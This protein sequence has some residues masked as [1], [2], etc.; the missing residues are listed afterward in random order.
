MKKNSK[1]SILE[2]ISASKDVV[3]ILAAICV[4][5]WAII[6]V[7]TLNEERI[8]DLKVIEL[9]QKIEK[10]S[11]LNSTM[12]LKAH[13][14][15]SNERVIQIVVTVTNNGNEF[16]RLDLDNRA[17]SISKV[18]FKESGTEY[19]DTTYIGNSRFSGNSKFVLPYLDI[20]SK[21]NYRLNFITKVSK[22]GIYL[23][24]FLSKKLGNSTIKH[25]SITDTPNYVN[26]Y[27]GVDDYIVVK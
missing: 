13:S 2:I 15:N 7:K 23:V 20:G 18:I 25:K 19:G 9:E 12:E 4:G 1:L 21:E 14:I 11:H 5:I 24:R 10:K 6:S 26:F 16:S 22:P 8:A 27:T 17:L 3:S